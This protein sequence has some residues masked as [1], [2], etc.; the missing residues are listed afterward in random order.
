MEDMTV[1]ELITKLIECPMD[2][3]VVVQ[4]MDEDGNYTTD[5]IK[6]ASWNGDSIFLSNFDKNK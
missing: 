1:R 4:V 6:R 5:S 2:A 3:R